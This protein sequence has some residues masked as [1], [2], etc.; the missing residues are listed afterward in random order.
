MNAQT[1]VYVSVVQMY[2]SLSTASSNAAILTQP[3]PSISME[4]VVPTKPTG[5]SQSA[6]L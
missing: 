3:V 2:Y 1:G 6:V 4:G 5:A